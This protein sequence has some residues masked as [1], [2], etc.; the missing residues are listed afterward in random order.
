M[1]KSL[2]GPFNRWRGACRWASLVAVLLSGPLVEPG[3]LLGETVSDP[4]EI[5]DRA[6][7]AAKHRPD[8]AAEFSFF[9]EVV[10]KELNARGEV[11]D[12]TIKTYRAYTGGR[13]QVLLSIN[14]R[15]ATP[16]EVDREREKSRQRRRKFLNAEESEGDAPPQ[17]GTLM[18]RNMSLFRDKFIPTL[19]GEESYRGRSV[20][21]LDLRPNLKHRVESKIV[22]RI[23]NQ[24]NFQVWVDQTEFEVA[25]LEAKLADGV[26]FFGGIAGSLKEMTIAVTQTRLA[27][28]HWVDNSVQAFFNA[29]FLLRSVHFGMESRS[30]QFEMSAPELSERL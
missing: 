15:P 7:A 9:R 6:H 30:S 18:S 12:K 10:V 24:L 4:Q 1:A 13:E 16:E 29:R 2:L 21:V 11:R 19:V 22:D 25:R 5:I 3:R 8:G 17:E 23:L 27:K 14:G 26:R 28:N 20:Y